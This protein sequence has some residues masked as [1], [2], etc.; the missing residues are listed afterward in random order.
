MD[1]EVPE[2]EIN[3]NFPE[4]PHCKRICE[5]AYDGTLEGFVE[6]TSVRK[7]WD[8]FHEFQYEEWRAIITCPGCG[9]KFQFE[10]ASG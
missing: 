6:Y 3:A 7:A 8:S 4:C 2:I 5:D 9:G 10:D 1:E